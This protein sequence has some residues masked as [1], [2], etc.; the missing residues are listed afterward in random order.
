MT[1]PCGVVNGACDDSN[2]CT[3]DTCDELSN[4][5]VFT[6]IESFACLPR[7][8]IDTPP[9]AIEIQEDGDVIV[10]G[11]VESGYGPIQTLRLNNTYL[12]VKSDN[13]FEAAIT[14]NFGMNF[15]VAEATDQ[16]GATTKAVQSFF[17]STHWNPRDPQLP[18]IS[19]LP[20]ALYAWIGRS[21]LDDGNHDL[22]NVDD[23][24]TVSEII[25]A[26]AQLQTTEIPSEPLETV[27]LPAGLGTFEIYLTDVRFGPPTVNLTPQSGG[28]HLRLSY[29][30]LEADLEFRQQGSTVGSVLSYPAMATAAPVVI[31]VDMEISTSESNG[32]IVNTTNA[33]VRLDNFDIAFD[34][35]DETLEE[36][37]NTVLDI[38][39][40][41][42]IFV[43]RIESTF[44]QQLSGTLEELVAGFLGITN[45]EVSGE[46]PPILG[47]NQGTPITLK[48]IPATAEFTEL[49]G[50]IGLAA[51]ALSERSVYYP[52]LGSIS[53]RGCT[54]N[55]TPTSLWF[56]P[57][58][59]AQFAIQDD[60]VNQMFFAVWWGGGFQFPV[61]NSEEALSQLSR[62][63]ITDLEI[64]VDILHAPI[65]TSCN[66]ENA[67]RLQVGDMKI[68][69]V[70]EIANSEYVGI[71]VYTSL[72][73]DMEYRVLYPED[74]PTI[75]L[76][77]AQIRQLET[78]VILDDPRMAKHLETLRGFIEN[79]F[80]NALIENL[81]TGEVGGLAIPPIDLSIVEG[82]PPGYQLEMAVDNVVHSG[83]YTLVRGH[84]R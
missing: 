73:A 15:L 57:N 40:L 83:E 66:S 21:A 29:A 5:C 45:F 9:R 19:Y 14:P 24:A 58:Y 35:E 28:I 36:A 56:D 7:I 63:G 2:P 39:L 76:D 59:S 6:P 41:K 50:T 71:D 17:K 30:W 67:I 27:T 79:F 72:E 84:P 22:E 1:T 20:E 74:T 3:K 80:I 68:R 31:D 69:I 46:F 11:R 49:G 65:L 75:S 16:G 77:F 32:I 54:Q 52:T 70:L 4:Q 51:S 8:I 25:V 47:G 48:A 81:T 38:N 64:D 10:R 42:G 43:S 82:V 26:N 44:E 61:D 55:D 53:R 60:F 78:E 18:E 23:L 37:I 33:A 34:L 13:T 62:L 12:E